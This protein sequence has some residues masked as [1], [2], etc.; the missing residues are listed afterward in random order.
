MDI[1]DLKRDKSEIESN[2]S[3]AIVELI[4][5]YQLSDVELSLRTYKFHT[6]RPITKDSPIFVTVKTEIKAIV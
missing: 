4:E 1:D 6:D 2:I 3:K 5:K